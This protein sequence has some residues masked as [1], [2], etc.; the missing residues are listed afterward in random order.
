MEV[1]DFTRKIFLGFV[2]VHYTDLVKP[3]DD[4]ETK[5]LAEE[6]LHSVRSLRRFVIRLGRRDYATKEV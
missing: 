1:L 5:F 4:A 2:Q 3:D 6:M